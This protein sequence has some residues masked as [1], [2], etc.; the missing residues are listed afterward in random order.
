MRPDITLRGRLAAGG[1][2]ACIG[3]IGAGAGA[4]RAAQ[5]GPGGD[6]LIRAGLTGDEAAR[7]RSGQAVVKVLPGSVESEVAAA[8]AIRITGDV[9]RLARWLQDIEAFRRALGSDAV[10]AIG[11]PARPGDFAAISAADLDLEALERCGTGRCSVRMPAAYRSRLA[12]DVPWGTADA[13]PR[14]AQ[15]VQQLLAAYTAAYQS[16]GDR[17]LDA[18]YDQ[19]DPGALAAG[20]RDML[21]RAVPV[22]HLA[23]DF[24]AYLEDFPARRP[25]G[26]EDRFYWTRTPGVRT[27][28]ATLHHVVLQRLPDRSLRLADKQF[29]ASLDIDAALL[30]GQATPSPD[31]RAFDLAVSIRARVPQAGS[32]A[33]RLLRERVNREIVE[34]FGGYLQWLQAS[35]ALG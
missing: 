10:G 28:I 5:P 16:G 21:R 2:A 4:G 15:V 24:A 3:A 27:S 18:L 14:A 29:Y 34:T 22:W 1:L 7:A 30:V 9:E 19:Q 26:V 12:S 6:L 23:Y 35:F 17:A 11:T 33:G 20:F 8:G 13:G 25:A 32:V 31:G